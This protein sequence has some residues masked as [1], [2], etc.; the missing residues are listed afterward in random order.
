[1]FDS[2]WSIIVIPTIPWFVLLGL[3]VHYKTEPLRKYWW[4]LSSAIICLPLLAV[5][6]FIFLCWGIGGFAP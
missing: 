4:G 6:G 1:M 5:D 2:F 3:L